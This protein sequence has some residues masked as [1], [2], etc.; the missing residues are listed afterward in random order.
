MEAERWVLAAKDKREQF[1]DI[2]S[3]WMYYSLE[4]EKI[5]Q[6]STRVAGDLIPAN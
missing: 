6:K 3:G 1:H 4:M 5:E 2:W